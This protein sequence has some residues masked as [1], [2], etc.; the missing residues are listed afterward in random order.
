MPSVSYGSR[1][2]I[3]KSSWSRC[4]LQKTHQLCLIQQQQT[5]IMVSANY[6]FQTLFAGAAFAGS[7]LLRQD[8]VRRARSKVCNE[9]LTIDPTQCTS[10]DACENVCRAIN[11]RCEGVDVT[12]NEAIIAEARRRF[13]D[14]HCVN[15]KCEC[16]VCPPRL[17]AGLARENANHV[18]RVDHQ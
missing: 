18:T 12:P 2:D 6:L 8:Q 4:P 10:D 16:A 17:L 3:H 9:G 15:S 7:L 14:F 1:S 13:Q 5:N 11:V